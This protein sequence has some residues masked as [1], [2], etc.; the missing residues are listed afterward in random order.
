MI[1]CIKNFRI[2]IP[3]SKFRPKFDP[4]FHRLEIGTSTLQTFK[5][6]LES[7]SQ[8]HLSKLTVM[9]NKHWIVNLNISPKVWLSSLIVSTPKKRDQFQ[10]IPFFREATCACAIHITSSFRR[11]SQSSAVSYLPGINVFRRFSSWHTASCKFPAPCLARQIIFDF[12][13]LTSYFG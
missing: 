5:R 12:H 13:Y 3:T 9:I 11:R 2:S 8:Q 7:H 6:N 10:L 1:P 4:L